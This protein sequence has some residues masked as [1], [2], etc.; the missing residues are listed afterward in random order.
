[1]CH[2]LIRG[3]A[4]EMQTILIRR[5]IEVWKQQ[6][7]K[8]CPAGF[9]YFLPKHLGGL[10][11]PLQG[12]WTGA[13]RPI[14][15]LQRKMARYLATSPATQVD[16]AALTSLSLNETFSFF[17]GASR[18]LRTLLPER[19]YRYVHALPMDCDPCL[20]VTLAMEFRDAAGRT[21]ED[22]LGVGRFSEKNYRYQQWYNMFSRLWKRVS[23]RP[24][25][26]VSM[27]SLEIYLSRPLYREFVGNV[28]VYPSWSPV[29]LRQL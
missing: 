4:Y 11:L 13:R 6:L 22:L 8:A 2:D 27:S 29:D 23:M 3:F 9:S 24:K 26:L 28:T 19:S 12:P 21:M 17:D 16:F 20:P 18:R 25:S 5:F 14:S 15:F 1:M 7:I 10:G